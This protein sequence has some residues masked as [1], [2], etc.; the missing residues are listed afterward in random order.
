MVENDPGFVTLVFELFTAA[1]RNEE[2]RAEVAEL[3]RRTR[4][5]VAELLEADE[6]PVADDDVVEDVDAQDLAGFDALAR[7]HYVVG[8]G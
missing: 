7:H 1:R 4:E 2:I 8:R 5:H 3:Y 6:A